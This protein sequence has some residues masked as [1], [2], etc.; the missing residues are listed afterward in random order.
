MGRLGRNATGALLPGFKIESRVDAASADAA[1]TRTRP[2]V[3]LFTYAMV[4]A[5]PGRYERPRVDLVV[6]M[7]ERDGE[8]LE[9]YE[10]TLPP[11]P[12][13]EIDVTAVAAAYGAFM[14]PGDET[15]MC[16]WSTRRVG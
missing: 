3:E 7:R 13:E 8:M 2:L 14:A 6:P 5:S 11:R 12:S 15:G 10:I 16:A 9:M 1:I 4:L